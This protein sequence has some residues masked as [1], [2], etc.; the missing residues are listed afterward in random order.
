MECV[1]ICTDLRLV[2]SIALVELQLHV[3]ALLD[4]WHDA[5]ADILDVQV[6]QGPENT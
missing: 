3:V 6:K 5:L 2:R 1:R 4:S